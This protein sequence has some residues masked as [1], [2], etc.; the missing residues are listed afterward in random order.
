MAHFAVISSWL[1][2]AFWGC[3][4]R[5]NVRHVRRRVTCG[6]AGCFLSITLLHALELT[7]MIWC[8]AAIY[9]EL[10]GITVMGRVIIPRIQVY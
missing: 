7:V 3:A 1:D 5:L 6:Y 9:V 10:L 2:F 8:V 4:A